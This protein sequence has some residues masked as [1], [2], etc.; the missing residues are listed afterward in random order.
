MEPGRVAKTRG[1]PRE[2]SAGPTPYI[3]A[4]DEWLGG[5]KLGEAKLFRKKQWQRLTF[6]RRNNCSMS[7]FVCR[8]HNG[9]GWHIAQ[10]KRFD[11]SGVHNGYNFYAK[12]DAKHTESN[13]LCKKQYV[14]SAPQC[15]PHLDRSLCAKI[16]MMLQERMQFNEIRLQLEREAR[17]GWAPT[18][19]VR[20]LIGAGDE[21]RLEVSRR[22]KL[23]RKLF[24][25]DPTNTLSRLGSEGEDGKTNSCV[26]C[27]KKAPTWDDRCGACR[28]PDWAYGARVAMEAAS[29]G[30]HAPM[31]THQ[32]GAGGL[33][34]SAYSHWSAI[35]RAKSRAQAYSREAS[36]GAVAS[37]VGNPGK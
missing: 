28:A 33:A 18:Q 9:C 35:K 25:D 14:N 16:D 31:G 20:A 26:E 27:C 13:R 22:S 3:Y 36:E 19:Q 34:A 29:G 8:R 6:A 23:L 37:A 30:V 10:K 2:T 12:R 24:K 11:A 7:L 21:L 32:W 15:P 4:L 1:R 17:G 5:C